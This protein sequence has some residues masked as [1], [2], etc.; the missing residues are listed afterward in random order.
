MALLREVIEPLW[1]QLEEVGCD[2]MGLWGGEV[3][4]GKRLERWFKG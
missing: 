1:G 4:G 2:K 3:G